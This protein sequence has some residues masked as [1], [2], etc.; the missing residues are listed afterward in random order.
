[1]RISQQRCASTKAALAK[2]AEIQ[3]LQVIFLSLSPYH[4][5]AR[6]NTFVFD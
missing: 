4:Q 5:H 1:V 3:L 6:I 2:Q